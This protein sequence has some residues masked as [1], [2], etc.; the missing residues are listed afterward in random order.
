MV[1]ALDPGRSRRRSE[2]LRA[3]ALRRLPG[4]VNSNVRLAAPQV[5]FAR[6]EGAWLW[7]VDGN[8]YV[9][10]LLGQG[11]SFLGHA[12]RTVNAAIERA[13]SAGM[14]YG[15]QHPLEVEAAERLCAAVGW[16]D[17]VR[18]GLSGTEM[19]QAAL[20]VARAATGRRRFVRFEGHYHGWLDNVLL[21]VVDG[22][23]GPAS[24]GQL[25]H[26]LDDSIVLPWNDA[27]VLA[28]TLAER[29][30]EVAAV[31]MEPMMLNAGAI[32][33]RPGYL[34]RVR[35]L[36]DRHGVVLIFDEVIC[37]FRLAPGGGSELFGVTP[38]LAVYGKAMAGGWPV[39]AFGG[40]GELMDRFGTGEVNHSG[41][42]NGSVMAAAATVATL[43]LLDDDPPYKRI[44]AHGE[45]L[46]AGLCG[47]AEAHEVPLRLQGLPVA[48]HASF[49]PPEP[50]WDF[51]GLQR[52]DGERY[53]TLARDFAGHGLWVA[54]R[55]VWY[56]SAAHGEDELAAALERAD[57][58]L[59]SRLP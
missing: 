31:I 18:F 30:E 51:R 2:E 40:R 12:N 42:F 25:A 33:P 39:A 57:R 3:R 49:G 50:V 43:Q 45:A 58:A 19:V 38:D 28:A 22:R 26:H 44:A 55:G 35:E 4:G 23:P 20:R 15:A 47:L 10:Y 36:C 8:D 37:G 11:P 27:D 9:D 21:G 6:A 7:D 53:A 16:L 52:L 56:V 46:M 17:M 32:P 5:F 59:S 34:A 29:A 14:V 48:F 54:G 13:C 24:A 1:Q 41:T